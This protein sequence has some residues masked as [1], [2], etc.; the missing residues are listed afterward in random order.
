MEYFLHILIMISI[1]VILGLS[2]NL[3]VGYTGLI[4]LN[5]AAFYGIGAYVIALMA[6]NLHTPFLVNVICAVFISGFIGAIIGFPALRIREDYFAVYTFAFQIIIFSVLNNWVSL[7]GGPIGLSGIPQPSI[8]TWRISSHLGFAFL[9]CLFLAPLSWIIYRI[10]NSPFGRVLKTIREDEVLAEASGKK[11]TAYKMLVLIIAAS[12]A[13]LAGTIY[14]YYISFI[15]PTSFTITE[16]I[17][18]ISIVIIG[19][20]GSLWGPIIG[21]VALVVLPELI[22]FLGLPSSVSSNIRQI[23]YGGLLVMFI[24]RRPQGLLGEYFF[25]DDSFQE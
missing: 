25:H 3:I 10:V 14:A 17:F 6:L 5:H 7:T 20:A 9:S 15:D 8:F 23:L 1:Y 2:L 11:V 21:A 16:S 18:I 19:G 4:S 22:R 12:T 13:A 24:M